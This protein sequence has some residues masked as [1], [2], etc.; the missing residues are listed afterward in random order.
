M[1]ATEKVIIEKYGEKALEKYKK[2]NYPLQ[3]VLGNVNF[4]GYDFLVN[5]NVLIP[6]FETELLIEKTINYL[7]KYNILNPNILEVGT[8]SGCIAITLKKYFPTSTIDAIDISKKALK[9]ATKNAD[10]NNVNINFYKKDIN[11]FS[12]NQKYDLIISNPPY[13]K[14]SD[15]V[16]KN[17]KY[18]PKK[19]LYAKDKGL[20]FYKIIINKLKHNLNNKFIIAFEIGIDQGEYLKE[21]A[22]NQ[23]PYSTILVEKDYSNRDR[24]LFI[25][26]E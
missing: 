12:N 1:D 23:F 6:R 15:E 8:G 24:Y 26:N 2:K 13:L 25:I 9:V 4:Y 21:Y 10:L 19:A 16:S 20:Q 11:K 3:Y 14:K 22:K 17:T 18:E 7:K 5:K